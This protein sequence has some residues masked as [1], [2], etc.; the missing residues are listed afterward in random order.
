MI[1]IYIYIYIGAEQECK[2]RDVLSVSKFFVLLFIYW[3]LI[4][5]EIIFV[6]KA[7]IIVELSFIYIDN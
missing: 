4:L 3:V 5:A 1:Y 7:N 2:W 6:N